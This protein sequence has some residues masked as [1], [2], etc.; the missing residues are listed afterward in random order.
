MMYIVHELEISG[1]AATRFLAS[2]GRDQG[3]TAYVFACR[4]CDSK[5]AYIDYL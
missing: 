4:H 3:P 1:A 2:L 5:L